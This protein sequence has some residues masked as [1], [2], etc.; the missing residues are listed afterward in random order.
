VIAIS[1]SHP[2]VARVKDLEPAL[3]TGVLYACRPVD[4][5]ALATAARAEVLM[6]HWS[7]VAAPDVA[8]AHAAGLAVAPWVS[9]DPRVLRWLVEI[10][11]D[12][13]GSNH[14]DVLRRV[15]SG[16]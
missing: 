10:G 9:S 2:V 5:A 3:T 15:T 6:P 8:A 13:I 4:A 14:P 16:E 7:Y 12:A 11:V 1:F